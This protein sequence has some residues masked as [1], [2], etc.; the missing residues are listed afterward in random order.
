MVKEMDSPAQTQIQFRL[1]DMWTGGIRKAN[2]ST[3]NPIQ[4]LNDSLTSCCMKRLIDS[5][6]IWSLFHHCYQSILAFVTTIPTVLPY[7]SYYSCKITEEFFLFLWQLPHVTT[8]LLHSTLACHS[9]PFNNCHH[10]LLHT[11][12][13]GNPVSLGM[14]LFIHT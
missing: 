5:W 13:Y 2:Q 8:V 10:S 7:H 14:T 12:K 9:L 4:S 1:K 11:Y 3:I 6:N